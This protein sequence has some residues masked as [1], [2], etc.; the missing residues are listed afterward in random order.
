MANF[1]FKRNVDIYV[2]K[3]TNVTA[4]SNNTVI[5]SVRD[6]SYNR[7]SRSEL[8][9]RNTINSTQPR[10]VTPFISALLPVEFSFITYISPIL[11]TVVTSPEEYLWASLMGV[12]NI[13]G[14]SSNSIIDF[15]YGNVEELQNLT[16]W[17]NTPNATSGNYRIDNAIIDKATISFDINNIAEIEWSGR[18]LSITEDNTVPGATDRRKD[19]GCIRNRFSTINL[20][21]DAINY[22]LA[23]IGGS[24][25]INNNAQF[26][27]RSKLGNIAVPTGSFT[28]NRVIGGDLQFYLKSGTEGSLDLFNTILSNI[29]NN[30]YEDTYSAD[31]TINIGGGQSP[32]ISLSFPQSI[33][34][35]LRK[36]FSDVISVTVPFTVKENTGNYATVS[37]NI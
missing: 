1:F 17:F 33:L 23:L 32:N 35:L 10:V 25:E 30:N 29:Q 7:A 4:D 20:T 13:S 12:D 3:G 15:Q 6:F 21:V 27:G 16:L 18:A 37:Y 2:S 31:I 19:I 28:G 26:Y 22:A 8:L 36:D 9:Q 11:D 24:V 14:D 34:E 5:L